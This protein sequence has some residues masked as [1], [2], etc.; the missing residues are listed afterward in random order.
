MSDKLTRW[1]STLLILSGILIAVPI[2]FQPDVDQA[3]F[4]LQKAWFPVHILFGIAALLG[5]A[6]LGAFY[7]VLGSR[8]SAIGHVA[9]ILA[10]LGN[11]LLAGL[12]FFV[13]ATIIPVLSAHSE[14]E[15]LLSIT[16]PLM[17]GPF[18]TVVMISFAI[19]SVG[20]LLL[21]AY[22]VAMR[23]ISL[24]NGILFIGA[25][26]AGFAPP[27]PTMLG[28]T[29]GVMLGAALIWLGLSVR[30]G[31]AHEALVAGFDSY[32]ECLLQAGGHA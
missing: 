22:L 7:H 17:S 15:A 13:E 24:L 18:G 32:D 10:L 23:T 30:S 1:S 19:M 14:Y 27:F 5:I 21:A 9:F 11:I 2:L 20:S 12:M 8:I 4:A 16:G 6:G 26:I 25:P 28:I 31:S 3:G 29:G